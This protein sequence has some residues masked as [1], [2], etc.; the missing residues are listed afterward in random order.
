MPSAKQPRVTIQTLKVLGVFVTRHPECVSG[1]DIF[2]ETR[3]FSG[4][5]Y[6]LLSRLEAARWLSSEWE[7]VD[8]S[9]VKR[10]RRR[11]YN[12]TSVGLAR[13]R[14]EFAALQRQDIGR[15]IG[16]GI[17]KAAPT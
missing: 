6:P 11:L 5:L 7:D 10:P 12:L 16:V 17:K 13:A 4:T 2:N 8:P 9:D 15:S 14:S 3:I 1:A